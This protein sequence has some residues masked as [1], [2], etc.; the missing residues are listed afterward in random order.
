MSDRK[1]LL[2]LARRRATARLLACNCRVPHDRTWP[3]SRGPTAAT[4]LRLGEKT[5]RGVRPA[6]YGIGLNCSFEE[7]NPLAVFAAGS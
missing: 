5:V 6:G 4:A 3:R 2:N 1:R 7:T